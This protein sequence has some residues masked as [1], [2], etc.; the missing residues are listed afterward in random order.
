MEDLE[1]I[2]RTMLNDAQMDVSIN[3]CPFSVCL[4]FYIT[5]TDKKVIFDCTD[6]ASFRLDKDPIESPM[7]L[8]FEANVTGPRKQF[9]I[10]FS[11]FGF[12]FLPQED[13][14]WQVEVSEPTELLQIKALGFAWRVEALS[15]EEW[16]WFNRGP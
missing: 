10:P 6:I 16:E 2:C 1:T 14:C 12:S 3:N 7:Y 13:Y 11:H 5:G 9:P 8:V 4:T 15:A